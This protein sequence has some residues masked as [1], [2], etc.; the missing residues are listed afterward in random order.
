MLL[1]LSLPPC[2]SYPP[3]CILLTL[4]PTREEISA[5]MFS[6]HNILEIIVTKYRRIRK[7]LGVSVMYN[8]VRQQNMSR[9][10]LRVGTQIVPLIKCLDITS[11]M[12]N[13]WEKT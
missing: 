6:A 3:L 13:L 4:S 10:A 8:G 1:P 5:F 9:D 11:L 12:K 2:I 7:M